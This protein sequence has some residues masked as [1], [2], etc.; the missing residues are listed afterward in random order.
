MKVDKWLWVLFL[1]VL[2]GGVNATPIG[3]VGVPVISSSDN[4]PLICLPRN[5]E[6][7]PVYRA[8]LEESFTKESIFWALYL[9]PNAEP[10]ILKSGECLKFDEELKGYRREG[11]LTLSRLKPNFTY[12][13]SIDRVND[14]AHHNHFYSATFCVLEDDKGE[15]QYPQ[16]V[17]SSA[18]REI[19]P[20]CDAR[21]NGN[22]LDQ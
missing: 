6:A 1:C 3:W 11:D 13:F 4:A 2:S 16:Y 14:V 20:Q 12:N 9:E 21:R 19:I 10:V 18:K 8:M 17:R 5:V 7:F 15:R 22:V